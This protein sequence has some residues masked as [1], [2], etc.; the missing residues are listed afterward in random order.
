MRGDK[1]H[2]IPK[3]YLNA[4]RNEERNICEFSR[5][6]REVRPRM[7][8]PDGTGYERGLY[9]FDELEAHHKDSLEH[10][11]LQITDDRASEALRLILSDQTEI[12]DLARSALSRFI[13]TL[14]YRVPEGMARLRAKVAHDYPQGLE[15]L[16]DI[17]DDWRRPNDPDSFD[18]FVRQFPEADLQLVTLGLLESIMDNKNIGMH[19]N[20][21]LAEIITFENIAYPILTSDRP[22]IMT[23]GI[24]KDY[25]HLLLPLSPAKVLVLTNNTSTMQKLKKMSLSGVMN[26]LIND[27]IVRQAN[28]YV[29]STTDRQ[30]RF[31][32][33][34]LGMAEPSMPFDW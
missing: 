11:F 25:G 16:R 28:K 12:G 24:G 4:W 15:G 5:P 7:V 2:Y 6:Y 26:E 8:N 34:R 20:N 3:F 27:R 31:V 14:F 30:L 33:N 21:M 29:Y 19:L 1:H 18:E 22:I 13:M 23:N 10:R 32:S 17:Y 9:T